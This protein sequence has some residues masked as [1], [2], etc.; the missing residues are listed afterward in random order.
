MIPMGSEGAAARARMN[1]ARALL[2]AMLAGLLAGCSTDQ[3]PTKVMVTPIA[4][5]MLPAKP[6]DC[7]MPVLIC[8]PSAPYRQIAIVEAWANVDED[9]ANVLPELKRQACATGAQALLI[10]DNRKQDI[11]TMLYGVTPNATDTKV[12]SENKDPN[13]AATYIRMM[14]HHPR[15]GEEGHTGFYIDA[16]AIEYTSAASAAAASNPPAP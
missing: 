10:V 15:V 5:A 4:S 13:Q 12:T 6:A 9:P 14:Q 8:D 7:D 3:T 2:G 16:L 11:H 1:I